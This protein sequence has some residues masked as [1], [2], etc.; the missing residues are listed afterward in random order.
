MGVILLLA[1]RKKCANSVVRL[2]MVLL[3]L[4]MII[5][6]IFEMQTPHPACDRRSLSRFSIFEYCSDLRVSGHIMPALI[7]CRLNLNLGIPALLMQATATL[8]SK[9]HYPMDLAWSVILV[10]LCAPIIM[11]A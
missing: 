9:S 6:N 4:K 8:K 10:Q 3:V 1:L 2:Y 11:N 7:L 5:S